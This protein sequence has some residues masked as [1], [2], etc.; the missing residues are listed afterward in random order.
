MERGAP[1]YP[2]RDSVPLEISN[3]RADLDIKL[4]YGESLRV[5]SFLKRY[6][7]NYYTLLRSDLAA[8]AAPAPLDP[9]LNSLGHISSSAVMGFNDER[10]Y[11]TI[12]NYTV[13]DNLNLTI[14]FI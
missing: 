11:L 3:A 5:L 6:F 7:S 4:M 8:R 9:L 14:F 12:L 2:P 10:Y 13:W 1:R